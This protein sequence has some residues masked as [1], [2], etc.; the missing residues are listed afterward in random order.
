MSSKKDNI[1]VCCRFRPL[2]SKEKERAD[3]HYRGEKTVIVEE[4]KFNFDYIFQEKSTQEEVFN[5][6][7]KEAMEDMLRGYNY[8]VFAYGQTAAG[9][10]F[11]MTGEQGKYKGLTPR[12]LERLFNYIYE[13][14]E[15]IEYIIKVSYIEIYLEK[16][17]DL[18]NPSED[19]LKL[20]EKT[21][22]RKNK[23]TEI[24]IEGVTEEFA[25]C[26]ED[27]IKLMNKGLNNR[28][29]GETKMN[30]RSSRSH[31]A[32][33]LTLIQNDL[34]SNCKTTSKLTL[35]DLAGSE[36]VKKT[37]ATGLLLKQAQATNKSLT[38]L[39][40]VIKALTEKSSHIPYRNSKLTR[41][42]TDSLGGNSKTCLIVACSPAQYNLTETISTLRFGTRVK[43]IKN[44]PRVNV[45]KS[46]R[47][48]K[49]L[50]EQAEKRIKDLEEKNKLLH[51][52]PPIKA[53]ENFEGKVEELQK[54]ILS[55]EE[56]LK[57]KEQELI[58]ITDMFQIRI[59]GKEN[60]MEMLIKEYTEKIQEK[61]KEMK[62]K[63]VEVEIVKRELELKTNKVNPSDPGFSKQYY[64]K[65]LESRQV[66]IATLE[67]ALRN[68]EENVKKQ[69]YEYERT[70]STL[71]GQ[72]EN[73]RDALYNP[74]VTKAV[75]RLMKP[76]KRKYNKVSTV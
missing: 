42:L 59:A 66:M 13:S 70:I 4:K 68:A 28:T 71:K 46:A 3:I 7:G 27:V 61:E 1:K 50:L 72:I 54:E 8:T 60:E 76:V 32:F 35:V 9:K 10:S 74:A 62:E 19:N 65:I 47:E 67:A 5:I 64:Q 57:K 69:K 58:D 17:R 2:N 38:N 26:Y 51:A 23:K 14:Q 33:I 20:R 49:T 73:L 30:Q 29:I 18:L 37:G 24:F 63:V 56:K 40:I 45:E 15:N 48:Y 16:I 43:T 53:I 22:G 39:G 41:L 36:T 12:L 34:K 25:S 75:K 44:K 21:E 55:L 11:S 31:S 6:A 52:N